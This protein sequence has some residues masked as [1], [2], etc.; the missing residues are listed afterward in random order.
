MFLL[1]AAAAAVAPESA[2]GRWMTETRH[3]VVEIA[4]CGSSVCGRLVDSDGIRANPGLLD[5][6]NRDPKLRSRPIKGVEILTGFTLR[7][8]QWTGGSVYNG[9]DGATYQATLIPLDPDHLKVRG[10]IIWP[11]CKTQTWTRSP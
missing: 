7:D 4:R 5:V 10:C 3:G 2:I 8:G 6:N 1:M 11:L 9:E